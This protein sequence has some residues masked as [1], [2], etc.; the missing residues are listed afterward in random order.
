M[1]EDIAPPDEQPPGPLALAVQYTDIDF[2]GAV[3]VRFVEDFFTGVM[4]IEQAPPYSSA[5]R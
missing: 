5:S 3:R 1:P 2:V 4:T